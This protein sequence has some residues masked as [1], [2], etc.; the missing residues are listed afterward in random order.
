[1]PSKFLDADQAKRQA[2]HRFE[3]G[4]KSLGGKVVL[5][6]GGAGGLGAAITALLLQ[7][8]A[9]PVVGYRSNKGH[10]LAFQQK[11]QDLYGGPVTLV[12]GDVADPTRARSTSR[13][14]CP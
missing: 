11:L 8:G 12:Q 9:L 13:S 5:V 1:M 7:D 14:R 2:E 10:A 6:A 4:K 3:F